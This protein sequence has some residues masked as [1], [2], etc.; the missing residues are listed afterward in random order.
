M[1][2]IKSALDTII[3]PIQVQA[4]SKRST[5][6]TKDDL[7]LNTIKKD[8][9]PKPKSRTEALANAR[10]KKEEMR[11]ERIKNDPKL[12]EK[13][14]TVY[15]KTAIFQDKID[16][17]DHLSAI[18]EKLDIIEDKMGLKKP[19]KVSDNNPIKIKKEPE[20]IK[21]PEE[22][23]VEQNIKDKDPLKVDDRIKVE[24]N[25]KPPDAHKI[26][27][28]YNMRKYTSLKQVPKFKI[29]K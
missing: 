2:D 22:K 25:I 18:I 1:S 27:E 26:F 20:E 3:E 5:V 12:Q 14:K 16:K 29:N 23:E 19:L 28:G 17:L 10:A 15:K 11:L 8:D 24:D 9:K 6:I 7:I 4:P 13:G 21:Y